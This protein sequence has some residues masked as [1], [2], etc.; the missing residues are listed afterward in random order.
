MKRKEK[1]ENKFSS[2]AI[3]QHLCVELS[4]ELILFFL[5]RESY[6]IFFFYERQSLL[7]CIDCSVRANVLQTVDVRFR[8]ISQLFVC[9]G[10]D[11][12]TL[13]ETVLSVGNSILI[14]NRIHNFKV[15]EQLWLTKKNCLL[16]IDSHVFT[17]KMGGW[18]LVFFSSKILSEYLKSLEI[19]S[20]P[21]HY[22]GNEGKTALQKRV[23]NNQFHKI[24]NF[25]NNS[26]K[27]SSYPQNSIDVLNNVGSLYPLGTHVFFSC[28]CF[29]VLFYLFLLW[30][31]REINLNKNYF[32]ASTSTFRLYNIIPTQNDENKKKNTQ[33]KL[34]PK[35]MLRYS[36]L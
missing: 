7:L 23:V 6:M 28:W 21:V 27:F 12:E 36:I 14:I 10:T 20:R 3:W 16:F 13:N 19:L 9:F 32:I 34:Y 26:K 15:N 11:I 18:Q 29:F 2:V 33:R 22:V 25:M 31:L 35:L 30:H 17:S 8:F 1:V 24:S 4:I 5:C